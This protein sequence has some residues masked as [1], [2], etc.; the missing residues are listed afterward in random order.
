MYLANLDFNLRT[1]L[2]TLPNNGS[3][4]P[5]VLSK[6][7]ITYDFVRLESRSCGKVCKGSIMEVDR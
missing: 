2:S 7:L 1:S 6:M 5:A 3:C 4:E